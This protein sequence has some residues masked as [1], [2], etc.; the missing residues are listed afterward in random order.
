MAGTRST[1]SSTTKKVDETKKEAPVKAKKIV[2]KKKAEAPKK[3]AP[4]VAAGAGKK[5][6]VIEACKQ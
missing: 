2:A 6:V 3:I 1:R 5:V 4:K